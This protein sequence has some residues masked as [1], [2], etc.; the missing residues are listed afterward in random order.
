MQST[1]ILIP[2]VVTSPAKHE[3]TCRLGRKKQARSPVARRQLPLPVHRQATA[4]LRRPPSERNVKSHNRQHEAE[5]VLAAFPVRFAIALR[6]SRV[7]PE[8]APGLPTFGTWKDKCF[9]RDG[10]LPAVH[11]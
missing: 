9:R 8:A 10:S 1:L 6:P 11:S 5:L 3:A 4:D 7:C 2:R